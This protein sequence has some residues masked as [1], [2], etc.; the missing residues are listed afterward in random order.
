MSDRTVKILLYIG[1]AIVLGPFVIG[2]LPALFFLA[3]W[4][5][6]FGV[7]IWMI[8]LKITTGSF[9]LKPRNPKTGRRE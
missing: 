5:I 7:P 6:T 9:F 8:Y 2:A 3:F 4:G 1:M